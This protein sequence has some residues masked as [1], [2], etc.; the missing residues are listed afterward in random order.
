M[1]IDTVLNIGFSYLK[2]TQSSYEVI[3]I[4]VS[5]LQARKLRHRKILNKYCLI[6]RYWSLSLDW[7]ES[8]DCFYPSSAHGQQLGQDA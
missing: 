6:N 3:I 7:C 8:D 1:N 2:S 4:V 5:I